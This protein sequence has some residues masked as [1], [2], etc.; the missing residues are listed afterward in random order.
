MNIGIVTTWFERGAAYV[1]R[2]YRDALSETN[3]VFIY[4]RGGESFAIGDSNWD[5]P[6]VTWA[7]KCFSQL[8]TAVDPK[9]FEKWLIFNKLDVVLF[10]EQHSWQPVLACRPLGIITGAYIDYYTEQ[11]VPFFGC[12]DFLV[13]NTRR[14]YSV[15]NWHPQ[16]FYLP[17]GTDTDQFKMTVP[18]KVNQNCVTFFH[19]GGVSPHRKG[20]DL[21]I[22]AFSQIKG[23]A[24]LVL[25]AQQKL[26]SFFPHLA[27]LISE[28]EREGKLECHEESVPAPGLFHLGDVYVYPTRLEGIG[29]TILEAN[30]CGL[31][32]IATACAPMTEFVEH[33]VNGR[34]IAIDKYVARSDGYYWPQAFASLSDLVDQMQWYVD[35]E[36]DL[37][38]LK[39][40]A[41]NYAE[42]NLSWGKNSKGINEIF[43]AARR[44]DQADTQLIA[45]EVDQFERKRADKHKLSNYLLLRAKTEYR[46][47]RF[48][49]VISNVLLVLR[50]SFIRNKG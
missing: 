46:F 1:S 44:L 20:C 28:L 33:K 12:Y 36:N 40:N 26:K 24:R 3:E 8:P 22:Q 11:T 48:F 25:H 41:R 2:Q 7:E 5:D 14:H 47:P 38:R 39:K 10:N 32:V 49:A 16:C 35:H 21:V 45:S 17:W 43:S 30:A 23:P 27:E 42:K 18:G 31:P 13:C 29:L 34:H 15:F 19:S 4:A 9:D 37:D 6:K 50:L